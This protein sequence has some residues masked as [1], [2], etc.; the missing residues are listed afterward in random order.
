M[1]TT[2]SPKVSAAALASAI[3][4]AVVWALGTYFFKGEVPEPVAILVVSAVTFAAGYL[5]TDPA[6][7]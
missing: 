1:N 2:V 5:K 4:G 3:A 7:N 6:A